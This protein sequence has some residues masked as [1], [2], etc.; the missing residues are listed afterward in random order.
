MNRR[1]A[2]ALGAWISGS[3]GLLA[4]TSLPSVTRPNQIVSTA[5]SAVESNPATIT[6]AGPTGC[7][8]GSNNIFAQSASDCAGGRVPGIFGSVDYLLFN[9]RDGPAPPIVQYV[10]TAQFPTSG[11]E[12]DP[13]AA[14]TLYG[15]SI[16]QHAFS[17]VNVMLGA[18]L[19][20][21]WGFD[22]SYTE[23]ETKSKDYFIASQG[24]PSI[25]R[26]FYNVT[27]DSR[28]LTYLV[29][30][31]PDGS[32]G[33]FIN[34][35]APTRLW[36]MDANIRYAGNA[37][38]ADRFD[39]LVGFRYIDLREGI[40][41]SDFTQLNGTGDSFFGEDRYYVTNQFYG[42][43][44]GGRSFTELGCGFTLDCSFKLAFG[45]TRQ[46]AQIY[47]ETVERRDGAIV[48]RSLGHV[49]TQPNNIGEYS[50]GYFAVAPELAIKLGYQ[51]TSRLNFNIGYNLLAVSNVIRAGSIIDEGVNPNLNPAILTPDSNNTT[52]RPAFNFNGTDFWAQGL[53]VGVAL[54]Y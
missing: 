28:P 51:V 48:N 31:N 43:Q 18:Y 33:G 38:F 5:G 54:N 23:F 42:A 1:L 46:T 21:T 16:R 49:L 45:G 41:V 37:I 47:G 26:Y 39:W 7:T 9:F 6:A 4:Q 22:V 32:V 29:I 36:T 10:P 13:N 20:E 25:G 12:L 24:D 3:T 11:Q 34:V 40:F 19:N 30:S 14:Q 17:G 27:N 44:V 52:G 50:R 35:E 2:F 15:G 8:S 53:T